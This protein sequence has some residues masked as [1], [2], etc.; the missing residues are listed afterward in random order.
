VVLGHRESS[1]EKV[2]W[3]GSGWL[4]KGTPE[5]AR[6]AGVSQSQKENPGRGPTGAEDYIRVFI[7]P[8]CLQASA[9]RQVQPAVRRCDRLRPL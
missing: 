6:L 7:P 5:R 3:S 8:S 2:N 4:V 1:G 9:T